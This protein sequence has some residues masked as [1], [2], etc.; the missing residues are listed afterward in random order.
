MDRSETKRLVVVAVGLA[1]VGVLLSSLL[2]V[3]NLAVTPAPVQNPVS[4]Q[5]AQV[6]AQENGFLMVLKDEPKNSNAILGL[7]QV[8]L[9]HLQ[10]KDTKKAIQSLEKLIAAAPKAPSLD[11]YKKKLADLKQNPQLGATAVPKKK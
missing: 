8:V 10:K 11:T 9:Y 4:S 1:S 2:G 7:E 3:W 5:D 6:T